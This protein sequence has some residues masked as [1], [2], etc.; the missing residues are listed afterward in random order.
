[1]T[2]ATKER[3]RPS[4]LSDEELIED[5]R[6]GSDQSY[7]ELYR[8]H[9]GAAERLAR[10]IARPSE[11]DDLVSDAFVNVL[12]Q[13]RDGKGPNVSFRAYLLTALRHRHIRSARS[14]QRLQVTD[15]DRQLDQPVEDPD[16]ALRA[17]EDES[18]RKAFESLPENWQL[19]LWHIEV[20]RERPAQVAPLLGVSANAVSALTY[21]AREG[22]RQA[23][24]R[25]HVHSADSDALCRSVV[26]QLP[27]YVRSKL[28]KRNAAA[29]H[30]H[31]EECRECY[32][33]F[34]E[35]TEVNTRLAAVLAPALLG[36]AG[37]GYLGT[38]SGVGL[39]FIA[40]PW[41]WL[42]DKVFGGGAST[43]GVAAGTAA[44]VVATGIAAAVVVPDL[45]ANSDS[46]D[47]SPSDQITAPDPSSAP[48][49][50][51]SGTSGTIGGEAD[52]VSDNDDS[53]L[54][55][56]EEILAVPVPSPVVPQPITPAQPSAPAPQ[57]SAP[58]PQ[59]S[60]PAPQPDPDPDP[61][62]DPSP[63]PD[64]E[65]V[66]SQLD[67]GEP[68]LVRGLL[69]WNLTVSPTATAADPSGT[70]E[71]TADFTFDDRIG[72]LPVSDWTCSSSGGT[73]L[74]AGSVLTCSILWN[75]SDAVPPVSI[76]LTRVGSSDA[77]SGSV[78]LSGGGISASLRT[79]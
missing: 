71:L 66:L 17:F 56:T 54:I 57:P 1:M 79:F 21:R 53:E 26:E 44:F 45:V 69:G 33:A 27:L 24:L 28:S 77:P 74:D 59:P 63:T 7:G 58:A 67:T 60:A 34:L 14:E 3:I 73:F 62:P 78:Q 70:I 39:A 75:A 36:T 35:L 37:I 31:L 55:S 8:R 23:Y 20:E 2:Q 49:S 76:W 11:V 22:L 5:V 47:I 72:Y 4:E 30:E 29:V 18:I 51:D 15:D 43:V 25:Q 52:S 9:K 6:N 32:A 42:Q 68:S 19:A 10:Q 65:Q 41:Q 40:H 12:G 61:T 50:G 13:L 46:P 16:A 48:G 38:T 64:P